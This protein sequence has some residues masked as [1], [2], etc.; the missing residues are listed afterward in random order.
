[1]CCVCECYKQ[2]G[3]SRDGCDLASTLCRYD[4]FVFSWALVRRVRW[5]RISSKLIM[6]SGG[7]CSI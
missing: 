6:C 5:G 1:M 7:M 2:R 4:L 3:H